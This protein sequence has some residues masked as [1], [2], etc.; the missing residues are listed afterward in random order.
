MRSLF[1]CLFS[2]L[3]VVF[4]MIPQAAFAIPEIMPLDKIENGMSGVAYTVVDNSGIIQPF[5]VDII[6]LIENGKGSS[7]MIMAKASGSVMEKTGGIL[8]GMSGSPVYI[9]GKLVGAVSSGLKEMSPY[10]FFITPIES[11]LKLWDMPDDKAQ[12]IK[13]VTEVEEEKKSEDEKTSEEEKK[14]DDEKTSDTEKNLTE[15]KTSDTE[16][17]SDKK[18]ETEEKSALFFSGFDSSGLNFLKNEMQPLGFKNFFAMSTSGANNTVKY[19]ASLEPG[20]AVGVA[21]VCGD[22]VIGATG[23]VTAVDNKKI[24]GFGHPFTHGGNVN[25]FMTDSSVIGSVSGENGNGVKIAKVGNIIGRIN[26]DREAGV[27]GIL[28][29]F[30]STVPITVTVKEPSTNSEE[31]YNASI[32]YNENLIPKIG[33]SIAY[34]ALSKTADSLAE[35]TVTVDFGIKTNVVESGTLTRK[36]MF[37]NSTDVG[38]VAIMELL[39]ALNIVCSNTTE[40]SNIYGIDVTMTMETERKTASLISAVPDKTKVKPGETVNLTVTLQPYRKPNEILIV[41]YTVPFSRQEGPMTLDLHGGSL[42]QVNATNI[43]GIVKP[44]N[45]SPAKNYE[46]KIKAL[47]NTGKNNQLVIEPGASAEVK[48]DKELK[49]DIER[50]KKAQ[51]R[52]LKSGKKV[53]TIKEAK[54]DTGYIIDNVIQVVINVDKV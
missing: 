44:S 35:S 29:K 47:L 25:F 28:G 11:M 4:I 21:V 17:E 30:P 53:P 8:Q 6:G 34:T 41:P 18:L 50:A 14:S 7:K 10:T 27:A 33:A 46:E 13:N 39:Q 38:Q 23:T 9:N 19:D 20:S 37:Y 5:N 48:S 1:K 43:A 36:N 12:I 52:F 54:F 15:E 2:I 40:E 16:K 3:S 49:K 24:L 22:F 42:V 45:N 51:E 32:A 26:Q 31:T